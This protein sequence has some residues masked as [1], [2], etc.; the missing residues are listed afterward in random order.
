MTLVVFGGLPGTGKTTLSA[1]LARRL[2]ATYLRVDAFEA[3][4]LETGLVATQHEIGPAGYVLANRVAG[5]C[6]RE[7][8]DVVVD[9][10]NPVEVARD[11]WRSLAAE[12]VSALTFV[13][14]TCSDPR[15]HRG[16]IEGR[17][18]DLPGWLV[19]DWA[20]VSTH[21]YEPWQGERLVVDN[22]GDPATLVA[23][24]ETAL[25]QHPPKESPAGRTRE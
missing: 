21:P 23:V 18:A 12:T 4:L 10:V 9:A 15:V 16:R 17:V 24:I 1:M 7:G 2:R 11:G 25:G 19:P 14:V 20:S 3:A 13:E 8:L 5:N 22:V 6:L